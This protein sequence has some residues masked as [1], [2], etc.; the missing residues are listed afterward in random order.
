METSAFSVITFDTQ[1]KVYEV[2]HV[3]TFSTEFASS[4]SCSMLISARMMPNG[5]AG[6]HENSNA[7]PCT[8]SRL[9]LL[10]RHTNCSSSAAR[11]L[12]M[13][14]THTKAP[15]MSEAPVGAHFLQAFQVVT[16]F[17]VDTVGQNVR[18]F[19]INDILLSVEKPGG[20]FVLIGVLHNGDDTLQF[21]R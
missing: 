19:S 6:H 2:M 10:L 17:G 12:G 21:F 14:T 8:L 4:R 13:L 15:E 7:F 16:K 20:N 1:S 11:R 18:V 9:T 5:K 3:M